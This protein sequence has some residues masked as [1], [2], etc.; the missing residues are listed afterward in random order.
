MA[1][2]VVREGGQVGQKGVG[3]LLGT[4]SR[5]LLA[6]RDALRRGAAVPVYALLQDQ[7]STP[8]TPAAGRVIAQLQYTEPQLAGAVDIVPSG[9]MA[10]PRSTDGVETGQELFAPLSPPSAAAAAAALSA[11]TPRSS[12]SATNGVAG[13]A[14]QGAVLPAD[15]LSSITPLQGT[16]P[17]WAVYASGNMQAAALSAAAATAASQRSYSARWA[18]FVKPPSLLTPPN[19]ASALVRQLMKKTKRPHALVRSHISPLGDFGDTPQTRGESVAAEVQGGSAL[20][21]GYSVDFQWLRFGV[22]RG[23]ISKA[24]TESVPIGSGV[25]R[26]RLS[27][28]DASVSDE[29]G[30]VAATAGVRRRWDGT[31]LFSTPLLLRVPADALD[32]EAYVRVEIVQVPLTGTSAAAQVVFQASLSLRQLPNCCTVSTV[33]TWEGGAGGQPAAPAGGE[34]ALWLVAHRTAAVQGFKGGAR[35]PADSGSIVP[36]RLLLLAGALDSPIDPEWTTGFEQLEG[37]AGGGKRGDSVPARG[38]RASVTAASRAATNMDM[39][40]VATPVPPALLPAAAGAVALPPAVGGVH[41]TS[42]GDEDRLALGALLDQLPYSV[43]KVDLKSTGVAFQP[44]SDPL[45]APSPRAGLFSDW[46]ASMQS[47]A[48]APQVGL[49]GGGV[50]DE[51]HPPLLGAF[52]E[53][54]VAPHPEAGGGGETHEAVPLAGGAGYLIPRCLWDDSESEADASPRGQGG[55]GGSS[56]GL[57]GWGVMLS[58]FVREQASLRNTGQGLAP[59]GASDAVQWLL[60]GRCVARSLVVLTK[61]R[62]EG[63][64][65]AASAEEAAAQDAAAVAARCSTLGLSRQLAPA[66]MPLRAPVVGA[67]AAN[68]GGGASRMDTVKAIKSTGVYPGLLAGHSS[69]V[70]V[71]RDGVSVPNDALHVSVFAWPGWEPSMSGGAADATVGAAAE[72]L[73][74]SAQNSPRSGIAAPTKQTIRRERALASAL[75]AEHA[76]RADAVGPLVEGAIVAESAAAVNGAQPSMPKHVLDAFDAEAKEEAAAAAAA[77]QAEEEA[78]AA[79]A[80]KQAEEEA[81]A[82]AAATAAAKQAEEEAAAAAAAQ[83]ASRASSAWSS[84]Q[85][86]ASQDAVSRLSSHH[87]GS[88]SEPLPEELTR[89]LTARSAAALQ[90]WDF[91]FERFDDPMFAAKRTVVRLLQ[92][93]ERLSTAL[94][95]SGQEILQLRSSLKS[96]KQR[97]ADQAAAAAGNASLQDAAT[98]DAED[99]LLRKVARAVTADR[100]MKTG[101]S[102]K[103]PRGAIGSELAREELV[104]AVKVLA[105]RLARALAQRGR[106]ARSAAGGSN[107][108]GGGASRTSAGDFNDWESELPGATALR[109][110]SRESEQVGHSRH[111]PP[112]APSASDSD[113]ADLARKYA[114]LQKA[115][116]KQS[117][118]IQ[119][120]QTRL[121]RVELLRTTV[122]TQESVIEKLQRWIEH[123]LQARAGEGGSGAASSAGSSPRVPP[124]E[125]S[126]ILKARNL[127]IRVLEQQLTENATNFAADISELRMQLMEAELAGGF[128]DSGSEDGRADRRDAASYGGSP[129]TTGRSGQQTGQRLGDD[130]SSAGGDFS[131]FDSTF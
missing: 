2:Y 131:D 61:G 130:A 78:A 19:L 77:K 79:A 71:F 97:S 100:P 35:S 120:L 125:L 3:H 48:L 93:V 52:G 98:A 118:Y 42:H 5:G 72:S 84:G 113:Y 127:R 14:P 117:R 63:Q 9:R 55:A 121:S 122:K 70:P 88:S 34:A 69:A 36:H 80:A 24:V 27:L 90:N 65:A 123:R 73:T 104:R 39:T 11:L 31:L 18:E 45:P 32:D 59:S 6:Y 16:P 82:A 44:R 28:H 129:R 83:P 126:A 75:A 21:A 41:G 4:A 99:K 50:V 92:E 66:V 40:V 110:V 46:W 58:V 105:K 43:G 124:E 17:W 74:D 51:E 38:R 108:V 49:L 64:A 119:S 67:A 60:P 102:K 106:G 8:H 107:E 116:F 12:G 103:L 1:A 54:G 81:A 26:V 37:G 53:W 29:G 22:R 101:G 30:S 56:A 95:G 91:A 76:A 85:E 10:T 62:A 15:G 94:R 33:L 109:P 23:W 20:Q 111:R 114:H 96:E 112:V 115:H 128:S 13:G 57:S 68:K 87:V 25:F 7:H 86:T 89:P 47:P